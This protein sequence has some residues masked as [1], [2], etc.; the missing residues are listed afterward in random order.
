MG[1]RHDWDI[2]AVLVFETARQAY[3]VDYLAVG[4]QLLVG[5]PLGHDPVTD[6]SEC[7][8]ARDLVVDAFRKWQNNPVLAYLAPGVDGVVVSLD[9]FAS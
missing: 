2:R 6:L 4:A 3:V 8:I 9:A 7:S 1:D 5:C